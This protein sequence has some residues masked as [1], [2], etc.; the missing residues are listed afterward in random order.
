MEGCGRARKYGR[1][2]ASFFSK[3]ERNEKERRES[4][5]QIYKM[6]YIPSFLFTI[7]SITFHIYIFLNYIACI[8]KHKKYN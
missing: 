7:F 8:I 3:L 1:G 5:T 6:T 4:Q 2:T